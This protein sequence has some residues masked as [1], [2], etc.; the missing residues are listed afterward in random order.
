M[1]TVVGNGLSPI[2]PGKPNPHL[3][4]YLR[5]T[6]A[7]YVLL[8]APGPL[9]AG[10]HMRKVSAAA[11][12]YCTPH[13]TTGSPILPKHMH[14]MLYKAPILAPQVPTLYFWSGLQSLGPGPGPPDLKPGDG[15]HGGEKEEGGVRLAK[16]RARTLGGVGV[17]RKGNAP[18]HEPLMGP[19]LGCRLMPACSPPRVRRD[20]AGPPALP[21]VA[22]PLLLLGKADIR[23]P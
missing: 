10:C 20:S 16:P 15:R 21:L 7:P 14:R 18:R 22:A 11:K 1:G 13:S 5:K 23:T 17:G 3:V 6:V 9:T 2:T 12:N 4:G 19:D 8:S